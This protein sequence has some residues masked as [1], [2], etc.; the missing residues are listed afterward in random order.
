M[1]FTPAEDIAQPPT[2]SESTPWAIALRK[3][4]KAL[5]LSCSNDSVITGTS[6]EEP[7]NSRL[8]YDGKCLPQFATPASLKPLRKAAPYFE[9]SSGSSPVLRTPKG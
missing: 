3:G 6:S 7:R 5:K 8:P 1:A 9:T 4:I 2:M